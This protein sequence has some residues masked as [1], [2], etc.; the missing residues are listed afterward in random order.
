MTPLMV[1]QQTALRALL[2]GNSSQ[3]FNVGPATAS[4]HAV[5]LQQLTAA[6]IVPG[7]LLRTS[8][9]RNN[10]GTLQ[11]S[12][13]GGAF[14]NVTSTF[15]GLAAS[16]FGEVEVIAGGGAGGGASPTSSGQC[17]AGSGG[18]GGGYARG[19]FAIASLNGQTVTVGAGGVASAGAAGTNGG[20]SS[21]GSVI[22][23]TGGGGGTLGVAASSATNSLVGGAGGGVGSNGTINA[24]GGVGQAAFYANTPVSGTGGFS[25]LGGGA[26][27]VSGTSGGT[28]AST[29]GAGGSGGSLGAGSAGAAT[30]GNG[31]PG[32]VII[33][34]YA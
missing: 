20:S 8:V 13:N 7:R 1:A 9:Y 23:A 25:F 21:V 18:G 17:S 11:V 24:V 30:G 16:A 15:N 34:E 33:R 26:G 4:T 28:N 31:A 14:T 27:P 32:L 19:I 29:P 12:I 2:A 3:V 5:Q 6:G 10:G 22:S